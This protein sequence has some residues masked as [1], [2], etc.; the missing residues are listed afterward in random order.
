MN[1]FLCGCV[2]QGFCHSH[3]WSLCARPFFGLSKQRLNL[4]VRSQAW[5]SFLIRSF[6][7]KTKEKQTLCVLTMFFS[8]V[9]HILYRHLVVWHTRL[10]VCIC[11]DSD[12]FKVHTNLAEIDSLINEENMYCEKNPD[13]CGLNRTSKWD[14]D[15]FPLF[16]SSNL[17]VKL[18][19]RSWKAI[20][21]LSLHSHPQKTALSKEGCEFL[22]QKKDFCCS[23]AFSE[24]RW[25]ASLKLQT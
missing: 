2:N 3:H 11:V 10:S 12:I 24:Q 19:L 18:H 5:K 15:L 8:G 16:M 21:Q 9:C 23:S 22:H 20:P 25:L 17:C 6:H 13:M 4:V 7:V 14:A 1:I